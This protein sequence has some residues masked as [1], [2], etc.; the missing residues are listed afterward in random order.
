M[1]SIVKVISTEINAFTARVTKILRFGKKD[2]RTSTNYAPY[3]DDSNPIAGMK[4]I[5]AETENNQ[6][7]VIIGYLNINQL[8]AVGEKRLYSTDEN[9]N[10][11]NYLWLKNNGNML[12]GGDAYHLARF[13]QLKQG[14][15]QLVSDFN[16]HSHSS[17]GAPPTVLSTAQIDSSKAETIKTL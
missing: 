10:V 5:F 14:F 13:E 16:L 1:V 8:A 3:G 9:G 11:K 7:T 4:A 17:N 2:V 6:K 15:D 12:L